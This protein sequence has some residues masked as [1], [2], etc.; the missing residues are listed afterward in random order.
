MF[1]QEMEEENQKEPQDDSIP[2]VPQKEPQYDSVHT[3]LQIEPPDDSDLKFP[4][5]GQLD[6]SHLKVPKKE[7]LDDSH[8]KVPKMEPHD[9]VLL[10]PKKELDDSLFCKQLGTDT[11]ED[12]VLIVPTNEIRHLRDR[13]KSQACKPPYTEVT[14]NICPQIWSI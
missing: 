11:S 1:N 3:V 10:V 6:D 2:L 4:K 8:L 7:P 9:S 14:P 13:K 12:D 5:E